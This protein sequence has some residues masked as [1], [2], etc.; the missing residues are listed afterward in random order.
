V[1]NVSGASLLVDRDLLIA[2]DLPDRRWFPAIFT[3][4]DIAF[5]VWAAGRIVLHVPGSVV[6]HA[7]SA[8]VQEGGSAY[9]GRRLPPFL[10]ARNRRQFVEKW[11]ARLAEQPARPEGCFP[12]AVPVAA[13][14]EALTVPA[15]RAA[16]IERGPVSA[17]PG[18]PVPPWAPRVE[19]AESVLADV[20]ARRAAIEEE[21]VGWLVDALDA[22]ERDV[23]VLAE[24]R[25]TERREAERYIASLRAE[26]ERTQ[27]AYAELHARH[28]A[29]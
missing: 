5:A 29:S 8:M 4:A 24:A 23:A 28:S 27:A 7:K 6:R 10:F 13:Q 14:I 25:E 26:L 16:A 18:A 17:V 21:F 20:R 9:R 19:V 12:D 11:G 3:D 1:D 2:L 15:Q 22:A